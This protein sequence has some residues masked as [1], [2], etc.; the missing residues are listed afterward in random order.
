MEDEKVE[1]FLKCVGLKLENNLLSLKVCPQ[2]RFIYLF[3]FGSMLY[4]V[5]G[6][7]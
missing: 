4:I 6:M 3:I 1:W 2:K 7:D 5:I